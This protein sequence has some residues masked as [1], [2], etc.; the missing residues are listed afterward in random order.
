MQ[1]RHL[2]MQRALLL[3]RRL[4]RLSLWHRLMEKPELLFGNAS[5][6]IG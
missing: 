2:L 5:Q 1:A 4:R 3:R 6:R